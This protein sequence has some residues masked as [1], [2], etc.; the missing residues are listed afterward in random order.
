MSRPTRNMTIIE[1][2]VAQEIRNYVKTMID[3]ERAYTDKRVF[4]N[5]IRIK[6][7]GISSTFRTQYIQERLRGKF[8]ELNREY[9]AY[10]LAPKFYL[11]HTYRRGVDCLSIYFN[12]LP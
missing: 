2:D 4:N 9:Y 1:R 5:V 10:F 6:F 7:F 8:H 3:Y 11:G 12:I